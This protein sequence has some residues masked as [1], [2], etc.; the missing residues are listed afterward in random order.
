M[1][2]LQNTN[3]SKM[4]PWVHLAGFIMI[5]A[6]QMTQYYYS[7]FYNAFFDDGFAVLVLLCI[8]YYFIE[9]CY[10]DS[11]ET[12]LLFVYTVW[13]LITR[14]ISGYYKEG[15]D[16]LFVVGMFAC[17]YSFAVAFR[18]DYQT[19]QRVL[20]TFIVVFA[21]IISITSFLGIMAA[22]TRETVEIKILEFTLQAGTIKG[23]RLH[24]A[25]SHP[26]IGSCW[27]MICMFLLIER[28]FLINKKKWLKVL[29]ALGI[30]VNYVA[31][32][33]TNCRTIYLQVSVCLA[34]FIYILITD[35]KRIMLRKQRFLVLLA[36]GIIIVP[37]A[38]NSFDWSIKAVSRISD[39]V[40]T[41]SVEIAE[42][43][44]VVSPKTGL[45][46]LGYNN[47]NASVQT[48]DVRPVFGNNSTLTIRIRIWESALG[49]IKTNP[50][51]L[52]FGESKA[53]FTDISNKLIEY[54]VKHY[55]N[56]FLNVLMLTGLPGLL[57]VLVFLY[58]LIKKIV[59]VVSSDTDTV[60]TAEKVLALPLIGLIGFG[61]T[62]EVLLFTETDIR[63]FTFFFVAG[64]L[65]ADCRDL[66]IGENE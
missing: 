9:K 8:V 1:S 63:A 15:T 25:D 18:F 23:G 58:C 56:M 11:T 12:V 62:F 65:L 27:A 31:I 54:P 36:C 6:A 3:T 40:Y 35:R 19:R 46:T 53:E 48:G 38:Y 28:C 29:L 7:T 39:A 16:L 45:M 20:N 66:R 64:V 33:L 13:V 44:S 60:T 49:T 26:N 17:L 22:I 4:W 57:I 2:N 30:F 61:A 55:H 41:E 59:L 21:T 14:L 52:L 47:I 5:F 24:I 50:S 32:A 37:L 43:T 34:L 42:E 10:K 51:V